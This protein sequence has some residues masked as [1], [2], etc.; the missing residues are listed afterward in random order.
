MWRRLIIVDVA[1]AIVLTAGV[2][3]VRRSWMEFNA[4]HRIESVQPENEAARTLPA[5][6]LRT[7]AVEDWTDISTKDPFSFDR[8]DISIVA[9]KEVFAVQPKP[10]LFGTMAIGNEW[11]AMLAPGQSGTRSGQPLKVGESIG[12]WQVVEIRDRSVVVVA[13][14]V[15]ET[16]AINEQ[17]PRNYERTLASS[18]AAPVNVVTPAAPAPAPPP[19]AS[20]QTSQPPQPAAAQ[21]TG[22]QPPVRILHTPFGDV[23]AV[24]PLK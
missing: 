10:V 13:N 3:R 20:P 21:P 19:S 1:L 14:G 6:N 23:P 16:V 4:N 22:A 5:S 15:R 2:V 17:Q 9:P 12:N 11:I 8:N 18:T 7:A 24:D